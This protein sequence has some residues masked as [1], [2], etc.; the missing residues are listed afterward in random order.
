MVRS[1]SRSSRVSRSSDRGTKKD[2]RARSRP[3]SSRDQSRRSCSRSAVES[4]GGGTRLGR[5]SP[6]S[7]HSV[8]GCCLWTGRVAFAL[9]LGETGHDPRI[10][11]G[12]AKTAFD[13]AGRNLLTAT[14][15]VDSV[16]VPLLAGEVRSRDP[17]LP[18]L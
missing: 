18:L 9:A 11:T 7:G 3:A 14:G 5:C 2:R 17:P 4:V 16:H 15:R 10:D 12:L 6:A 8:T 13:V 1:H